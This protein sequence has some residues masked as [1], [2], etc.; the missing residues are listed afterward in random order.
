MSDIVKFSPDFKLSRYSRSDIDRLVAMLSNPSIAKNLE[1][2][3][4]PYTHNDANDWYNFLDSERVTNPNTAR[5]RYV[6][7][8]SSSDLLAGDISLCERDEE[9]SYRLGYWLA[10]E[11]W[12][13]GIM[14]KAVSAV[15]GIAK[16]ERVLK[17][18]SYVK[19]G[20]WPSRRVLEKNNFR[21]LGNNIR[22]KS[23]AEFAIWEFE[24]LL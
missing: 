24:L 22:D 8:E 15:V 13:R 12:G 6:I 9:G 10:E 14:T 2:P 16:E 3:P 17:I 19:Q 21:F 18:V 11:Y 23:G 20:N 5:F 7:R 1:G 4:D